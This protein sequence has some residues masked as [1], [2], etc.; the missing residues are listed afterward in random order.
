MTDPATDKHSDLD[1][2]RDLGKTIRAR[3]SESAQTSYTAKL[4]DGGISVCAKKFGEEAVETLIAAIEDDKNHLA[5]ESADMLYHWLVMLEAADVSLADVMA[6][7]RAR[8]G[9]GGLVEKAAST[10]R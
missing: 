5:E 7:L 9:V 8:Q 10:P 1:V 6:V 2:L 3:K 4:L